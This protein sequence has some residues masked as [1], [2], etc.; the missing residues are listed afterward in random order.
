[1]N[2]RSVRPI[3]PSSKGESSVDTIKT[4]QDIDHD[5]RRFVGATAA[6][7]AAAAG[8]L[9]VPPE[10]EAAAASDNTIRSFRIDFPDAELTELRRRIIATKW[11]ERETVTDK[12]QGVQ[13]ATVQELARNWAT[14][15]DW[16]K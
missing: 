2:R 9:G 16:R 15:Y 11:P 12:S 13:L 14:D 4:S 6:S 10:H 3:R 8:A 1:M 7:V 5:R